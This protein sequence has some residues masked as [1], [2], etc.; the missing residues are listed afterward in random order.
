MPAENRA[1]LGILPSNV[2][3][4]NGITEEFF[5]YLKQMFQTLPTAPP[6]SILG[7]AD[8]FQK[9]PRD[10]K[11]N[12]TVGVYRDEQGQTPILATVKEAERR[13]VADEKSKGYLGIDGHPDYLKQVVELALK[14]AAE[15]NRVAAVQTPGG[16]G[17]LRVGAET[18]AR[19]FPTSRVW[20]SNPTWVNHNSIF[21]ACGLDVETYP[22]LGADKTS[23]DLNAMLEHLQTHGRE[24]DLVCLHACCHNPTGIDPSTDDWIEIAKLMKS[25][26]MIPFVDYAYQGFGEGLYEDGIGLRTL[27]ASNPEA[28]ICSSY[29][30]NFGLYSE[31]VGAVMFVHENPSSAAATLS[32]LKQTVRAN[33]SN[34]PRHGAATVALIL[35]DAKLRSEWELEVAAMRDR[36]SKMRSMFVS[37]MASTNAGRNFS[38]LLTQ[39]GMFSYTGLSPMQADWLK[40]ERAIYLVGTGRINVAGIS[41]STVSYI[42]QSIADCLAATGK[43]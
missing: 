11:I 34:P 28:I 32:Q 15:T 31:R 4:I 6:D 22:Y 33:Y 12:L 37:G 8:V 5:N 38:F 30:K 14:D 17:A 39:K 1:V 2:K 24:A 29:S 16:T 10:K 35:G 43:S 9:D 40:S 23:F 20:V 18:V 41:E 19:F 26:R 7:L 3:L 42:C 36:I 25:K 21:A 27:L 13:L